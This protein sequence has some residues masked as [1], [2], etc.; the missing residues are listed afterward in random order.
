MKSFPT[1][2]T[3]KPKKSGKK[4][5]KGREIQEKKN[6]CNGKRVS[7]GEEKEKRGETKTGEEFSRKRRLPKIDRSK[8]RKKPKNNDQFRVAWGGTLKSPKGGEK[9]Y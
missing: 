9:P 6:P 4:K 5:P 2:R 1:H 8:E 7:P 3:E